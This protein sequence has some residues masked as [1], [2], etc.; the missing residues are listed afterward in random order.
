MPWR[1]L[2]AIVI[3]LLVGGCMTRTAGPDARQA[4]PTSPASPTAIEP[5]TR[6]Q[7]VWTDQLCSA[8]TQ[9]ANEQASGRELTTGPADSFTFIRARHYLTFVASSVSR[10]ADEFGRMAKSDIE[11]VDRYVTGMVAELSRI[12]PEVTRLA[13]DRFTPDSLPD[14]EVRKRVGRIVELLDS[15]RPEGADLAT[16]ARE[17]PEFAA[18][19]ELAPSCQPV[20]PSSTAAPGPLPRAADGT[21]LA[22]CADGSCEVA[23]R[24]KAEVRVGS[25]LLEVT[26]SGGTVTVVHDYGGGGGGQATLSGAG[27]EASFGS[28]GEEVTIRLS[29]ADGDRAVVEFAVQ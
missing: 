1:V 28:G 13:G 19:Y 25:F 16:L 6:E 29:G 18:R 12:V 10:L 24:G 22:A 4:P 26:V 7:V 20:T 23:L 17:N 15:V 21:D 8:T 27:S 14:A 5:P 3:L 9:L 11:D 2:P